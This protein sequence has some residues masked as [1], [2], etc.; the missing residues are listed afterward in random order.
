MAEVWDLVNDRGEKTGDKILRSDREKIPCG[1]YHPCV[2]IWVKVGERILIT[3][4]HP[5][6]SDGLKYDCPGG[7][8]LSG[9][10]IIDGA[11]RELFEEVGIKAAKPQLVPLGTVLGRLVYAASFL[12]HLDSLPNLALQD[13]EVVGYKLV[14]SD[15]LEKISRE[16]THG[17]YKRYL[18]YKEK[19]FAKQGI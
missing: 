6:K 2:E 14:T 1:L 17:T 8:V 5:D 19:I 7:A 10:E 11:V 9:E 12:L 16:L 13:S 3:Q 18:E 15:E 4:R